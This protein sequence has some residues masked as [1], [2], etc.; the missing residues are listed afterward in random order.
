MSRV[1]LLSLVGALSIMG[2]AASASA[3]SDHNFVASLKAREEVQTPAVESS[4][5][6]VAKFK[7]ND[8]GDELS[9]KLIV[10]NIDNVLFSHIHCGPD[11][12]NGPIIAFLYDGPAVT[13]N[14][15]LAEGVLTSE[16]VVPRPD[17]AACPGG[18]S[19][20]ADLL[21]KVE[22]GGAYVNVH[23]QAYP[24]GEIRGQIR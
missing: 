18:V 10:A 17:S 24:A 12:V 5:A 4:A 2:S 14:G 8:D 1:M 16:D 23:T 22:N 7:L 20:F 15:V 19:S 13:T 3:D 9:F 6:G 11:G 21:E